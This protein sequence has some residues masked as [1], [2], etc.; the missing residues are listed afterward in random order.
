MPSPSS[1][2]LQKFPHLDK[3]SQGSPTQ[4]HDILY[5][6]DYTQCLPHLKGDDLMWL[7]EYLDHVC[8]ISLIYSLSKPA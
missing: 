4:L 6:K 2:V 7:V 1:P 3:L 5:G 8:H